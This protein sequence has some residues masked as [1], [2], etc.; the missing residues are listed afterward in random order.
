MNINVYISWYNMNVCLGEL[1]RWQRGTMRRSGSGGDGRGDRREIWW[2][3]VRSL[4]SQGVQKGIGHL[5][6]EIWSRPSQ[7]RLSL[8]LHAL[9]VLLT[10]TSA[11]NARLLYFLFF[12]FLS[13]ELLISTLSKTITRKRERNY[14]ISWGLST[15]FLFA[16]SLIK[17]RWKEVNNKKMFWETILTSSWTIVYCFRWGF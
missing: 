1:Y 3:T 15:R 8:G 2:W 4:F 7:G 10:A 11:R 17:W 14:R 9:L 13:N 6:G 16:I 12:W 5:E